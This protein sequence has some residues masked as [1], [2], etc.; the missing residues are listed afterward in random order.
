M[1]LDEERT[2]VRITNPTADAE[3]HPLLNAAN[4]SHINRALTDGRLYTAL[5]SDC[6]EAMSK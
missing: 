2:P 6:F 4:S 3:L 1:F 5:T